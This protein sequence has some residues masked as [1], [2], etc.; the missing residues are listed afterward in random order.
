MPFIIGAQVAP[1]SMLLK[2]PE[3]VEMYSV[4]GAAGSCCISKM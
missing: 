4:D 3:R 2:M 1:E